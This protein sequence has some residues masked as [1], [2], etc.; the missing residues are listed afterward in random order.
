VGYRSRSPPNRARASEGATP[1]SHH[2]CTCT[3]CN[4]GAGTV[5]GVSAH[6]CIDPEC[7]IRE[8]QILDNGEQRQT[9]TERAHSPR[10]QQSG[11]RPRRG[12]HRVSRDVQR[13]EDMLATCVVSRPSAHR[14][15]KGM[16]LS[17]AKAGDTAGVD[18]PRTIG[19]GDVCA[20]SY[21]SHELCE[22][23]TPIGAMLPKPDGQR[24]APPCSMP[25]SPA[26]P[27]G[28]QRSLGRRRSSRSNRSAS[29]HQPVPRLLVRFTSDS[30][31]DSNPTHRDGPGGRRVSW[32]SRWRTEA[33]A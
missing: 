2:H 13:H 24:R 32:K 3:A 6:S 12:R 21:Q 33:D 5:L 19:R 17:P 9:L 16:T 15:A 26:V 25:W 31:P 4:R 14:T 7:Q 30:S 8:I 22:P 10:D 29:Q 1:T 11:R 28:Q 18:L 20:D 27:S 23:G